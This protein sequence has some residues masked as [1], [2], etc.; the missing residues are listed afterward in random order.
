MTEQKDHAAFPVMVMRI[1]IK[2]SSC[3]LIEYSSLQAANDRIASLEADLARLPI[4]P[5][6][7]RALEI[8]INELEEQLN[9]PV[10]LNKVIDERNAAEFTNV[11]LENRIN[12]LEAELV[13]YKNGTQ[14]KEVH[15]DEMY[16]VDNAKLTAKLERAKLA[17]QEIARLSPDSEWEC[18]TARQCLTD[19]ERE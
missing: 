6:K 19:L 5:E 12:E 13:Y 15:Y 1:P 11:M 3:H 4:M 17:L 8:R 2:D 14:I 10:V 16:A 18:K 9:N 7:H